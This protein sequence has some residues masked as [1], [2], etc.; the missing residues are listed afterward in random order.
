MKSKKALTQGQL[1]AGIVIT[2]VAFMVVYF[3]VVAPIASG[4][5]STFSDEM[6]HMNTALINA[7]GTGG[8]WIP[9]LF[10]C[11]M[12]K[13]EI[14]ADNWKECPEEYKTKYDA[15]E[16]KNKPKALKDCAAYQI[17]K[18]ADRCWYMGGK[19]KVDFGI[20][21]GKRFDCFNVVVTNMGKNKKLNE[22]DIRNG[23]KAVKENGELKYGISYKEDSNEFSFE[24]NDKHIETG[25]VAPMYYCFGGL[26]RQVSF[27]G[28][29]D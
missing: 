9:P 18:L 14:K 1:V 23:I 7:V 5:P 12:R 29:E 10:F 22:N 27:F 8:K 24:P 4:A 28:C 3:A 13:A 16:T 19:G 20:L 21:K 6:C 25:K 2:I 11:S 15:A 17:G 26:V